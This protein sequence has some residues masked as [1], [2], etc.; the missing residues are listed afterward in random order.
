MMAAGIPSGRLTVCYGQ[1]L[2]SSST[3]HITTEIFHSYMKLLKLLKG[4][5]M[6]FACKTKI[7]AVFFAFE[8]LSSAMT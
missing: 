3:I 2:E 7:H 5:L 1:W 8:W 4:E 6:L